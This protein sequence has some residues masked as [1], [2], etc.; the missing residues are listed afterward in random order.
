MSKKIVFDTETTGF[1]EDDEVLQLSIIDETGKTLMNEY[2]RPKNKTEWPKAQEVNKISPEMVKDKPYISE[3]KEKIEKILQNAEA[4]IGYNVG[5]D[6]RML[7]QCGIN[8]PMKKQIDVM[9][10]FAPIYKDYDY[11]RRQYRY[12]NLKTCAEYYGYKS[13]NLHDSLEDCKAT[14]H[15]YKKMVQKELSKKRDDYSR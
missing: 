15:C 3:Y 11:R 9:K 2:F 4:F 5:Y 13:E 12:K 14:L 8:V 1:M 7:E 6:I 10:N